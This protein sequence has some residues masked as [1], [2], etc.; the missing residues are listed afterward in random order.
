MTTGL[1]G[2]T[3]KMFCWLLRGMKIQGPIVLQVKHK[4]KLLDT[5]PT[6]QLLD[7]AQEHRQ[8]SISLRNGPERKGLVWPFIS[9]NQCV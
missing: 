1:A 8:M 7:H 5:S 6:L 4:S 3:N 2:E 9:F